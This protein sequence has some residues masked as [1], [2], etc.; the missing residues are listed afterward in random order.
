MFINKYMII[1]SDKKKIQK[2][3]KL[4]EGFQF[5]IAVSHTLSCN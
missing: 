1:N 2:K 3:I 4:S 5:C